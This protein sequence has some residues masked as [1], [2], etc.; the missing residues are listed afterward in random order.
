M[1]GLASL[2]FVPIAFS[3]LA[4]LSAA[5]GVDSR[6]GFSGAADGAAGPDHGPDSQPW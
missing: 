3:V 1:D 4:L 6:D 2:L 5:F